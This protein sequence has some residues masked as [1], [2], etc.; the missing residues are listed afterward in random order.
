MQELLRALT[1]GVAEV[2][3]DRR[4]MLLLALDR[5]QLRREPLTADALVATI[6]RGLEDIAVHNAAVAESN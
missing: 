3:H 4:E 6:E 2:L 5:Y 1:E